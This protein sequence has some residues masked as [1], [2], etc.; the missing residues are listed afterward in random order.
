MKV[1]L[2]RYLKS[3]PLFQ[4]VAPLKAKD[5][6]IFLICILIDL[7]LFYILCFYHEEVVYE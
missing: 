6:C 5:R 3:L 4:L 1:I 7:D 2:R